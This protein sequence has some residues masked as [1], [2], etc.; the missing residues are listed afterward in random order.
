[1]A[2][3]AAT[4]VHTERT[5][6]IGLGMGILRGTVDL[7]NYN[8]T[9]AEITDI[10]NQF[11]V[12][13]PTVI[14]DSVSDNGYLCRWNHVDK[15]VHAF[16][17]DS[18]YTPVITEITPSTI[19]V[20]DDNNAASTGL[21]I[22]VHVDE[23][24]EGSFIAHLESVTA[25]DA[26][27]HAAINNGG[28]NLNIQD[29]DAAAT[30][31]DQLYFDEDASAGKRFLCDLDNVGD[32]NVFVMLE[33]GEMLE[34]VNDDSASS[35]GVLVYFDDDAANDYERLLF[36]SPTDT[37]GTD[38]VSADLAMRRETPTINALSA[39]AS[40]EVANDVNVGVVNFVA[41]GRI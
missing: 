26:D 15:A 12:S 29:D 21:V 35:N 41:F 40:V 10:T 1:M 28:P 7:T 31:G 34:I 5:H 3:Y 22:Y 17:P 33:N 16:Y 36:V 24:A 8:Q 11:K 39:G 32:T 38:T 9:G 19:N 20:K 25:G 18:S 30:A 14:L 23:T 13:D 6:R 37:N 2:A 4:V 27:A